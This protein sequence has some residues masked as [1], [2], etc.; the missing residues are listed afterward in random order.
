MEK[1]IPKS[2]STRERLIAHLE[3]GE[4]FL[5]IEYVL[6]RMPFERLNE[7]PDGL[8]YS[9]YELFYHIYVAQKD[10][11]EYSKD[12]YYQSPEWPEGYWPSRTG[13]PS[14]AAWEELRDAFFEDRKAFMGL[15][16]DPE[17]DLHE[18]FRNGS[19]HTLFRQALLV[20][21]HAA[22]HTG[23]LWTIMRRLGL[24]P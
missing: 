8:P 15:I 10:L 7:R 2:T 19:G 3:G 21:E 9:F 14:E 24:H 23:Q 4:A 20:I 16:K 5:N 12:S 17:R 6:E 13:P 11:L 22:Y 18:P 1:E